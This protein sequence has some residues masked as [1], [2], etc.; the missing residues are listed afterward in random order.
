M[1]EV[2]RELILERLVEIMLIEVLRAAPA[3][4]TQS[5]LLHGLADPRIANALRGLHGDITR[6]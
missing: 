6:P 1:V 5:G 2:G 4:T 3:R